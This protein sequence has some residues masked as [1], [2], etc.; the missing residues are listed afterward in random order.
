MKYLVALKA[1]EAACRLTTAAERQELATEAMK[2]AEQR[3]L[4]PDDA[5][6]LDALEGRLRIVVRWGPKVVHLLTREEAV[7]AHLPE[8]ADLN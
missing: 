2:E 8:P 5:A 7:R 4:G 3:N 6:I 1:S